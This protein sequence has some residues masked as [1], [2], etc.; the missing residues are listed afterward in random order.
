MKI[1]SKLII[2]SIAKNKIRVIVIRQPF[3]MALKRISFF[4]LKI[5][6][7][8]KTARVINESVFA[9]CTP[10]NNFLTSFKWSLA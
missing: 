2:A 8:A 10:M 3:A 5:R 4:F 1:K 7:A 9:T 6:K